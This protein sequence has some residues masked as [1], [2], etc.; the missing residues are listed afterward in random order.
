MAAEANGSEA[1]T[2]VLLVVAVVADTGAEAEVVA[3][4]VALITVLGDMSSSVYWIHLY[5]D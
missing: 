2:T 1:K 3:V 4:T 5:I